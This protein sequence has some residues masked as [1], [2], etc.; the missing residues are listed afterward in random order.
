M[1]NDLFPSSER[2]TL[3]SVSSMLFSLVMIGLSPLVGAMFT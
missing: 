3:I 1:L 2:A